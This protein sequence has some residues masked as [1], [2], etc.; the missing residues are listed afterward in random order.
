[1]VFVVVVLIIIIII[2]TIII[3]MIIITTIIITIIIITTITII[4]I[5]II[6]TRPRWLSQ[7]GQLSPTLGRWQEPAEEMNGCSSPPMTTSTEWLIGQS[8]SRKQLG[9]QVGRL[10]GLLTR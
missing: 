10:V 7:A 1:M 5:I 2:I 6:I 4:I 9:C 8:L 3:I